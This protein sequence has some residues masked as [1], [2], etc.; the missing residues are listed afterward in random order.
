[1]IKHVLGV[2]PARYK[3]SRFP[4][5]PLVLLMGKPMILWVAELASKALGKE[6]VIVAT[7]D[8]RIFKVVKDAG[9]LAIM[10]SA[11]HLTGTDRI[12]EVAKNIKA[13]IYI[14]IQ[15]DEPTVNPSVILEVIKAKELYPDYVVNA[16]TKLTADEDP[17][18]INIPKVVTS[19][20]GM[21]LY[22]SRSS[23]PGHK[24]IIHKPENYY[25]QVCIYGFS[26][27]QLLAFAQF[28]RKSVLEM[29]E[30]IEILRY[31]ELE[32]KIKMIE[33]KSASFA[34]DVQE[35]VIDVEKRL[36]EVHSLQ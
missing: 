30:D 35:D 24:D 8:M 18:N 25:K 14:N 17:E 28:G 34:V 36:K 29:S 10:T 31:L 27:E 20:N 22:M 5:K 11:D 4:G 16:M 1:M 9:Y 33:I 2:I 21:M 26:R 13:D 32:V 19:E 6:N 12:A 7:E 23:I 15:G 3:S